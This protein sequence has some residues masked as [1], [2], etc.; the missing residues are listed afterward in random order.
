[1]N[2]DAVFIKCTGCGTNNRIPK[3]RLNAIPYTSLC[4]KCA[5]AQEQ[6]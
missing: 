6:I 2:Q 4:I 5:E 3:T 1:M